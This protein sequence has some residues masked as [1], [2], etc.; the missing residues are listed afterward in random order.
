MKTAGKSKRVKDGSEMGKIFYI[1]GKS[2]TGKD[3]IFR[4]IMKDSS[5]NLFNVVPYTTRPIRDGEKE[6]GAYHYVSEEDYRALK[7]KSL[8]LEEETY[9][10]MHGP[11]RYFTV[12]DG[13]IDLSCG[14]YLM[15]GVLRS[16]NS[17]K[18]YYGEDKVIPIYIEVDDG[19][20]LQR[21]LE[22]ELKPENR[23]FRE[24]CRRYLADDEDFSEDKLLK[25]GVIKRYIND[26]LDRCIE[27]IKSMIR[28]NV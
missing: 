27:E 17:I 5:L 7:E 8:I 15:I 28:E 14:N 1:F 10:T 18:D 13:Q 23:K 12:Q 21:A 4:S 22:R 2:S 6:G 16:Y 25:S 9:N 11:W 19:I 3:T 26:D 24:M 20:R